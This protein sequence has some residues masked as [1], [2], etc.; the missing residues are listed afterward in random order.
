M[1]SKYWAMGKIDIFIGDWDWE[2]EMK[3]EREKKTVGE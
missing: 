2:K 3:R 1:K